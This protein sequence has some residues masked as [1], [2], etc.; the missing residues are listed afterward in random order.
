ML[1]RRT[2]QNCR[3]ERDDDG[4]SLKPVE[5]EDQNC[6][7]DNCFPP[8][9]PRKVTRWAWRNRTELC[10]A[11]G[12]GLPP[13]RLP[14]DT[15]QA[16]HLLGGPLVAG[17]TGAPSPTPPGPYRPIPPSTA[18]GTSCQHLSGERAV[19]LGPHIQD[20]N[21]EGGLCP[22][23]PVKC[24]QV[25]VWQQHPVPPAEPP[26]GR[27]APA[28]TRQP[29]LTPGGLHWSPGARAAKCRARLL[30]TLRPSLTLI[31]PSCVSQSFDC[32]T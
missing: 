22:R 10:R 30:R 24:K 26:S 11:H 4:S 9:G 7:G 14:C 20:V 27:S 1:R 8:N 2:R 15:G 31:S 18:S 21:Q 29:R 19:V 17:G 3:S 6:S 13:S 23:E 5:F 32:Q 12:L 28:D 16:S 25:G